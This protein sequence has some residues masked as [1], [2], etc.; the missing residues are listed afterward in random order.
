MS[1]D[2]HSVAVTVTR[3]WSLVDRGAPEGCWPWLGYVEDGYGRFHWGG[4]MVGAHELALTFT[5]GEIRGADLDTCHGCGNS[6]CCNPAHLRFDTRASNVHDSIRHGTFKPPPHK[7]TATDAKTIRERLAAGAEGKALA[8][9]YGISNS[10]VSQIA[11]G[12]RWPDA[13]GPIRPRR[14]VGRPRKANA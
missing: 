7:I 2:N 12:G 9:Q 4:R 13:G 6:L 11:S 8:E 5:T 10:L 1:N 3:F 14:P